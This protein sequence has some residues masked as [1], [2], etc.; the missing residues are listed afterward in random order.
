MSKGEGGGGKYFNNVFKQGKS[1]GGGLCKC[2]YCQT[3]RSLYIRIVTSD[4][5]L[6]TTNKQAKHQN[7]IKMLINVECLDLLSCQLQLN[8]EL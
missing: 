5:L 6:L 8:T 1:Y 2:N 7:L 4:L 3:I